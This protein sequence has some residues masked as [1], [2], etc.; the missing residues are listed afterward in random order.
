MPDP[1]Q[2]TIHAEESVEWSEHGSD[3]VSAEKQ[4]ISYMQKWY[5][6]VVSIPDDT[7]AR[8]RNVLS[9]TECID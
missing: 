3:G 9:E 8:M 2:L 6:L 4:A 1:A 7:T 5:A